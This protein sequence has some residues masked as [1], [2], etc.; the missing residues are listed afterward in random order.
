MSKREL[1]ELYRFAETQENIDKIS[2]VINDTV[3]I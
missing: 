1:V 2:K 3:M